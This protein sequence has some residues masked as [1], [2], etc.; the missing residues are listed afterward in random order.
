MERRAAATPDPDQESLEFVRFCYQRRRVG[1]PELYDEMCAVAARGLFRGYGVDDLAGIGVGFCLYDMPALAV[2]ARRVVDEE[3]A[4]RRPVAVRI[5]S[6]GDENDMAA[7]EDVEPTVPNLRLAA[8][9]A[10]A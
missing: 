4:R 7:T 8:M 3:Q 10:G 1:W 6:A 5:V 9:P 2:I